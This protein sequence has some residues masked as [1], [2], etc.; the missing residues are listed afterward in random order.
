VLLN[1]FDVDP[2]AA[3][4]T[5]EIQVGELF[6]LGIQADLLVVSARA[7]GYDPVPGTLIHR[8]EQACGLRIAGL[9]RALDFSRGP[10]AAWVSPPLS[11]LEVLPCWPAA[12]ST[13]FQRVAVIET[14]TEEGVAAAMSPSAWSLFN[15]MFGLLSVL[16]LQ[17]VHCPVVATPLLGAG[18]QSVD[19]DRLFPSLLNSCR[20]GFRHVPDL[21]R[22]IL[23]DRQHAALADLA[24][25]VDRELGRHPVEHE[26]IELASDDD[27]ITRLCGVLS[28][29]HRLHP[30]LPVG[31]D[32]TELLRLLHG[33]SLTAMARGLHSRRL[34]ER[35]VI[36][37]VGR[38][39]L[40]LHRAFRPSRAST[41]IPGW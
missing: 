36:D 29:F 6:A 15:Q 8:L 12:S 31:G 3:E 7:G 33:G 5:L 41:A 19:P 18:H 2:G 28:G 14:I 27:T 17:G 34:V 26:A 38:G 21:E 4:R 22:L 11:S 10:L 23:F 25:L 37:R 30:S 9:P 13:R 32:V 1:A 40:T 20:S 24:S 16:P 35:L 39:S